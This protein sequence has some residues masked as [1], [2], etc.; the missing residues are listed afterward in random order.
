MPRYDEPNG[1]DLLTP[2]VKHAKIVSSIAK[3]LK[4]VKFSQEELEKTI[5]IVHQLE[6]E[7]RHWKESIPSIIRPGSQIQPTDLPPGVNMYLVIFLHFCY[8]GSLITIHSVFAY[9][10]MKGRFSGY[11]NDDVL[12]QIYLS[13][14]AV[15]ESA[16]NIA[17]TIKYVQIDSSSPVWYVKI[18]R[19]YLL[20]WC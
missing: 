4:S 12:D 5:I 16:R 8:Y 1:L 20:A 13:T 7:L 9:P 19:E 17:L 10:W 18:T 2:T 6:N 3:H 14:N 15:V 11:W